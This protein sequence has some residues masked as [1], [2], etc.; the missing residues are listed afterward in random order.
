MKKIL[1]VA[2]VGAFALALPA[3]SA[4]SRVVAQEDVPCNPSPKMIIACRQQG[5]TFS[6]SQC[7]CIL[8]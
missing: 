6:F 8:P 4:R 7:K 1:T 5:G 2:L 3:L